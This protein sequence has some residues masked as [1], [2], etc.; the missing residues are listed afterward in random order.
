MRRADRSIFRSKEK[1]DRTSHNG[2]DTVSLFS[3][4]DVWVQKNLERPNFIEVA[5]EGV[6][7][8]HAMRRQ[9]AAQRFW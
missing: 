4:C 2:L 8:D 5:E 3:S 1:R 9:L 6:A 7:V